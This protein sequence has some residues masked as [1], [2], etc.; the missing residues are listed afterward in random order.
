MPQDQNQSNLNQPWKSW[1]NQEIAA[2]KEAE[3]SEHLRLVQEER[4]KQYE[5]NLKESIQG[6]H[7]PENKAG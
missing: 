5:E 4:R 6:Y 3:S 2:R 7:G 1:I